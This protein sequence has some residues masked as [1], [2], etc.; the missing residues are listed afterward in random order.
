MEIHRQSPLFF[1]FG[2]S[3][4]KWISVFQSNTSSAVTQA[5]CLSNFFELER[6]CRQGDP[7]SSYI[8]L[9]C[10]EILSIKIKNNKSIKGIKINNTEYLISQYADETVL[11]L[12]GSENSLNEAI[13]ELN[14]FYALSGLKIN[15]SKTQ[16]TWIGS[17][18]YSIEKICKNINLQWTTTFKLLGI[19]F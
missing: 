9:I 12:D 19:H 4:K 3:I 5:G 13:K 7:I 8:F 18:K 10:A 2:P 1:N 6:G 15:L 11:I 16:A 17:K 14:M